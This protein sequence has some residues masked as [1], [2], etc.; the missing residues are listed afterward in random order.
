VSR[1]TLPSTLETYH[2]PEHVLEHTQQFLRERGEH[3]VEG[4][5][6][7]LGTVIDDTTAEVLDAYVPEQIARQSE[8]GVSV[9]VTQGG[10]TRLI[11]SLPPGVFVLIRVH[12][13]PTA[14]YHSEL[15]NENMLISHERAISVVVPHFARD[16]IVLE[17]C[18]VNELWHGRGWRELMPDEVRRRFKVIA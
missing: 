16:P 7:W 3:A 10:L 14:A 15:D 18:S 11:S 8:Y 17:R 4:A 5:V 6:L 1:L 13:H 12:S 9:E 2:V